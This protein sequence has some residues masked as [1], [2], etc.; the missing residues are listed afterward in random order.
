MAY[1]DPTIGRQRVDRRRRLTLRNRRE[2][3]CYHA[4]QRPICALNN[5]LEWALRPDRRI[6]M[7]GLS[8]PAYP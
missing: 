6:E 7:K 8:L 4:D 1:A 2:S 3:T 5:N